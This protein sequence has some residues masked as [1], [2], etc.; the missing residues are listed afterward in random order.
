MER[1]RTAKVWKNLK[2]INESTAQCLL[3]PKKISCKGS[4]TSGL[5]RHLQRVHNISRNQPPEESTSV[6][7]PG[8]SCEPE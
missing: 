2:K 8:T 4:N 7:Q 3:C 1:T 6:T 5:D